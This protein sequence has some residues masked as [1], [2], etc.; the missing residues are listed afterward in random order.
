MEILSKS[1]T[2]ARI[3]GKPKRKAVCTTL[4]PPTS[5]VT[6]LGPFETIRFSLAVDGTGQAQPGRSS[7]C[8]T[9]I[10]QNFEPAKTK[11]TVK[12]CCMSKSSVNS[13]Y[14]T[15]T[16][17]VESTR[18]E[19]TGREDSHPRQPTYL[20]V[21]YHRYHTHLN[22]SIPFRPLPNGQRGTVH[23]P[24]IGKHQAASNNNNTITTD[25]HDK[26]RCRYRGILITSHVV[27]HLIVAKSQIPTTPYMRNTN[28]PTK[29]SSST[30]TVPRASHPPDQE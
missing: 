11:L 23:R 3:W 17:V 29:K 5:K 7:S 14:S 21:S 10:R 28:T 13:A 9:Y 15:H 16:S 22:P 27:C 19:C 25:S 18:S 2:A 12:G 1:A 26:L 24:G 4:S 8:H 30:I 20:I 6:F